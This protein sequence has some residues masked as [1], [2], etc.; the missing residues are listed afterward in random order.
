M[1]QQENHK[2]YKML[3]FQESIMVCL[4]KKKKKK[5]MFVSGG[6]VDNTSSQFYG[7]SILTPNFASHSS[8]PFFLLSSLQLIAYSL[9]SVIMFVAKPTFMQQKFAYDVGLVSTYS[10]H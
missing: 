10:A 1:S 2:Y 8:S 5:K 4:S 9:V 3:L 6:G 7:Q